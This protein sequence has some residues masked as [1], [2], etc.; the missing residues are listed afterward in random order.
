ML[1][2]KLHDPI[3]PP[4]AADPPKGLGEQKGV[5]VTQIFED[6]LDYPDEKST[7]QSAYSEGGRRL[8]HAPASGLFLSVPRS[9]VFG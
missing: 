8:F 6:R 3:T 5:R 4:K 7:E 1:G 9:S 2:G